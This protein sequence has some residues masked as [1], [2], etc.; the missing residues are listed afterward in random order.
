[1]FSI[2]L[3]IEILIIKTDYMNSEMLQNESFHFNILILGR[4]LGNS[5]NLFF[6]LEV[7]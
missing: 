5:R 7:D 3:T 2:S 1:M 4:N 6:W